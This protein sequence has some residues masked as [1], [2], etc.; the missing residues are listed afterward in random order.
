MSYFFHVYL[1]FFMYH[2]QF[3]YFFFFCEPFVYPMQC[4]YNVGNTI[5]TSYPSMSLPHVSLINI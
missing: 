4:V 3:V 5:I 2:M 1:Y